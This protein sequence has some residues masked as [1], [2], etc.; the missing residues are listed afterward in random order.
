MYWSVF[1]YNTRDGGKDYGL[2]ERILIEAGIKIVGFK[3]PRVIGLR[4]KD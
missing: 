4:S 1:R 2:K 3:G